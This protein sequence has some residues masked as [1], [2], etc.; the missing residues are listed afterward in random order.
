MKVKEEEPDRP[1]PKHSKDDKRPAATASSKKAE[2]SSSSEEQPKG[3]QVVG[4]GNRT[5]RRVGTK[6]N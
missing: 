4:E 6:Y 3:Q 1:E 2:K 5:E